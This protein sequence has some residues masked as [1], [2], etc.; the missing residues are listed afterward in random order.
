MVNK[1][2][3][4]IKRI[5]SFLGRKHH[6]PNY[7]INN[8]PV[9]YR[10][11]ETTTTY[12]KPEKNHGGKALPN[13]LIIPPGYYIFNN[14]CY[15]LT[16]EGLYR[17]NLPEQY[18]EQRIVY[19]RDV[20]LLMSSLAWVVTHGESDDHLAYR[21][22]IIKAKQKKLFLTCEAVARFAFQLLTELVIKA[23]IIGARTLDQWNS[24]DDGHYL[25]EVYRDDLGQWVLY[26]LDTDSWFLYN[27]KPLS[28]FEFMD[29]REKNYEI[30]SLSSD[31]RLK[32]IDAAGSN[33][34]FAFIHEAR[35]ANLKQWYQ[36]VMQLVFIVTEVENF[37]HCPIPSDVE[38]KYPRGAFP[39]INYLERSV[40]INEFY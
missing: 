12:L 4:Y 19:H 20:H 37:T 36:R 39:K 11:C 9:I 10:A 16:A 6:H 23:R 26:D 24:Y 17:F 30:K 28:L 32:L 14:Q 1:I 15:D 25:L 31:S 13:G 7:L 38:K 21:N 2:K 40:F 22:L 8:P 3:S 35:L 29:H 34:D 27:Q 5:L 33:Y 18:N